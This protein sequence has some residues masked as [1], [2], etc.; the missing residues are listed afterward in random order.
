MRFTR[1][2]VVSACV[3]SLG[4]PGVGAASTVAQEG[5]SSATT[6]TST[7]KTTA[8]L[9]LTDANGTYTAVSVTQV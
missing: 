2:A 8:R 6:S 7:G 4:A 1:V 5:S 3:P 9:S